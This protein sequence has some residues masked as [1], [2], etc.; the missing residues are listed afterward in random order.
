MRDL[1]LRL[2]IWSAHGIPVSPKPRPNDASLFARWTTPDV[3]ERVK[4][5]MLLYDY[6]QLVRLNAELCGLRDC[7]HGLSMRAVL[8]QIEEIRDHLRSHGARF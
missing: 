3:L 4:P 7:V 2:A 5:A 6:H 1:L 8:E